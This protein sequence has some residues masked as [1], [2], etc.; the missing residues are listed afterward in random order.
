MKELL[1]KSVIDCSLDKLT[2]IGTIKDADKFQIEIVNNPRITER[3]INFNKMYNFDSHIKLVQG[4]GTSI[5]ISRKDLTIRYEYNPN[6]FK[7][8]HYKDLGELNKLILSHIKNIRLSRID[9]ALD[10]YLPNF[11]EYEFK[12]LRRVSSVEYKS[13]SEVLQTKYY[14]DRESDFFYR[15]Y[16]KAAERQAKDKPCCYA[17][18]TWRLEAQINANR[19]CAD[20]LDGLFTPFY[21]MEL[22]SKTTFNEKYMDKCKNLKEYLFFKEVYLNR[23]L[24][25]LLTR[26]EREGFNK[27]KREYE[28]F[29][30]GDK[31]A[32]IVG[33]VIHDKLIEIRQ[34]LRDFVQA[35][36]VFTIDFEARLN[37]I[38][39][40]IQNEG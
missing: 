21:D 12:C 30:T 26:R 4:L 32:C 34:E 28:E 1:E 31:E 23:Q 11:A 18:G 22:K 9:I 2:V 17:E 20:F 16:D 33:E 25:P 8:A 15:L 5:D 40:K 13:A 39:E 38:K 6:N 10:M 3:Y 14:G 37:R 19:Q 36:S 7:E 29:N 24:L 35:K 27:L